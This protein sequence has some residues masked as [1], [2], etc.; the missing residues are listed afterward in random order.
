VEIVT[1]LCR[2]YD[3]IDE[4]R[5]ELRK[6]GQKRVIE[7]AKGGVVTNPLIAQLRKLE[8]LVT[9]YEGLCGLTPSDRSRLGI[10]EVQR[11]SK[12][13]AFLSRR[14]SRASDA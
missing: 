10:A 7:T 5:R 9:R 11:V 6:K 4:I 14:G 3:E 1:R 12:L 13:D 8:E 2:A